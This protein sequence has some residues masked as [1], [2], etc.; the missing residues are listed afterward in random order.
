M[1]INKIFL[2]ALATTALLGMQAFKPLR[3][4]VKSASLTDSVKTRSMLKVPENAKAAIL[5]PDLRSKIYD[6][7]VEYKYVQPCLDAYKIKGPKVKGVT[8]TESVEFSKADLKLWLDTLPSQTEYTD[9]R[10]CFGLYTREFIDHY[11]VPNPEKMLN[12][13]TVFLVP[14]N[15]GSLAV[16]KPGKG[17]TGN[18]N[19]DSTAVDSFNLGNV[20]P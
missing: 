10:I 6:Q 12:R 17:H 1:K 2:S 16:Y 13:L 20:H 5:N 11:K 7:P 19:G 15:N 18:G 14:F 9:M 3:I 4:D 8:L